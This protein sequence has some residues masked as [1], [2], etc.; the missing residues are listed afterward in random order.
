MPCNVL[1][2]PSTPPT[3]SISLFFL[4]FSSSIFSFSFSLSLALFAPLAPPPWRC[5]IEIQFPPS[6]PSHLPPP[7]LLSTRL[8]LP[9]FSSFPSLHSGNP[10][11]SRKEAT[12]CIPCDKL[13]GSII[14]G[15]LLRLCLKTLWT[16]SFLAYP[17][18]WSS[19]TWER[20]LELR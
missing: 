14:H 10:E 20:Y 2:P 3:Y 17:L 1:Q 13:R 16:L 9:F 19:S 8:P 7:L 5:S 12:G 4:L 18:P 15:N 6:H 11:D